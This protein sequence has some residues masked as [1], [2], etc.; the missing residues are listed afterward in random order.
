[1]RLEIAITLPLGLMLAACSGPIETRISSSGEA[2]VA[3]Q[4]IMLAPLPAESSEIVVE[5]RKLAVA[6]LDERGFA[7]NEDAGVAVNVGVSDRPAKLAVKNGDSIVAPTKRKRLLQNCEDRE[8][9]AM[10]MLTRVSDGVQLYAGEAAEYHCNAAL[11][12]VLPS[13]IAALVSDIDRPRGK[14]HRA[15]LGED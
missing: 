1:M 6:E 12:K 11:T 10:L 4:P 7:L 5:A 2:L 9:T 15:R 3:P 8:Y 13:L 14:K